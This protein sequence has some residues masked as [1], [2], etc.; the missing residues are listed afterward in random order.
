MKLLLGCVASLC[1]GFHGLIAQPG[2]AA[3]A[4]WSAKDSRLANEY[5]S[6]LVDRPE[7]GRVVDLLWELYAKRNATRLLLDNIHTQAAAS[8]HPSVLLVE[9]HLLR[10]SGDL[11]RAAALYDEVL[12]LKPKEPLALRARAEVASESG[13][14]K[15]AITL[16]RQLAESLPDTDNTKPE[17]WM[18]LGNLALANAQPND[19]AESW[20]RAA[21][22]RPKDM[23]MARSIAQLLLR[24]GFPERAAAFLEALAKASDPQQRL[25]ALA[26][27]SR[28]HEL[29]DQFAKADAALREGL[30]ILDFHDAR[31]AE[32]FLRRVR[33]HERFGLLEDLRAEVTAEAKKQPA[34]ELALSNRVRF[35]A[36]TVDVDDRLLGLRELVKQVP[37][38]DNYRWELVRALL[39]HEGADEAAKLL[40]ERLH[41][42]ASDLPALVLLRAEAEL[43]QG[44]NAAAVTRLQTLL[45]QQAGNTDVEKAVL[46]FAQERTLDAI[47]ESVLQGR[48]ERD[49]DKPEPVF[50]LATFYKSRQQTDKAS[51]L[52]EHFASGIQGTSQA[53]PEARAAAV[54]RYNDA[55]TFLAAGGL[56]EE[57]L[58]LQKAAAALSANGREEL[59]RLADFSAESGRG[60]EAVA[61]LEQ[62]LARST[63]TEERYDIDERLYAALSGAQANAEKKI[64]PVV[65]STEFKLPAF[66]SGEGFGSDADSKT[67][68]EVKPAQKQLAEYAR[69]VID[70]ALD[71]AADVAAL[72]RGVW[73]L[74]QAYTSG[75]EK[76]SMGAALLSATPR[77]GEEMLNGLIAEAKDRR[78]EK[79]AQLSAHEP[80]WL[81]EAQTTRGAYTLLRRLLIDP[82]TH[83]RRELALDLER[84]VLDF[85]LLD[86][87]RL[88][89]SRQLALLIQ[90]DPA[91]RSQ[92][93]LRLAEQALAENNPEIAALELE[94]AYKEQPGSEPL[95]AALTQCYQLLKQPD[96]VLPLWRDAI[97]RTTGNAGNPLRERYAELLLKA[98]K[99]PEHIETQVGLVESETDIK[100]RREIFTRFIDR[101]AWSDSAN[102]DLAATIIQDRLKMVETALIERSRRHPFDGF[103]HEALAA[104]YEKRGDAAKAFAAMRQAYY[105]SPDTPFSLDQLRAA[106]LRVGD[107]KAATY[108]QKQIVATALAKDVASE[109]RQLV[110][111]L[112]Q[113]FQIAEAD[114]VRRRLESRFSQDAVALED[115]AQ[116]YKETGQDEAERRVYEQ[117]ERVRSWDARSTLRLALK[118][119]AVSDEAAAEKHLR[120]ILGRAQT[121]NS[122]A[123]LPPE[124]WPFPLSDERKA[125]VS[126][127]SL[128]TLVTLLEGTRGLKEEE[129]ERL[130]TFLTYPR[131]ELVELP[132]DASQVRLRGIE[133]LAKL[134]RS[135]G[136]KTLSDWTTTWSQNNQATPIEKLWALYYAGA[137][138]ATQ[139]ALAA[140]IAGSEVLDLEFVFAWLMLRSQG[141][142][143]TL[144]WAQ[145]ASLN[146]DTK[147]RRQRVLQ[148]VTGM[149]AEAPGFHFEPK[150]LR[151]L[152]DAKLLSNGALLQIVRSFQDTQRYEEAMALVDGVRQ[153]VPSMRGYYAY[154]LASFAQAAEQWDRQRE[155]LLAVLAEPTEPG[156]Y[157]GEEEDPFIL[158]ASALARLAHSPQERAEMLAQAL[159]RLSETP[160]SSLTT[161]RKAALTALAGAEEPAA[162]ALGYYA[163][164]EFIAQH[165]IAPP[166]GLMP[167]NVM[168]MEDNNHLRTYWSDMRYAGALLSQQGLG[169]LMNA[170]DDRI[171]TRLGGVPLGPRSSDTFSSWRTGRLVRELRV[172]NYPQRQRLI[173]E[174]LASVDMHEED[175]VDTLTELGREL[176]LQGM[177][178]ECIEVYKTLPNRAPT[179]NLYAGY[180]IRVCELAMEPVP[181]REYVESLFGKDP[182]YK[183]QGIGDEVL[184]EKHARF[185]AMEFNETRLRE[186]AIK[187]EGFTRVMEGRIPDEVP[188]L[189]E[190]AL[191]REK[192]GDKPG[193]LE[194]WQ[195]VQAAYNSVTPDAPPDPDLE[196]AQHRATLLHALGK[197]KQAHAVLTTVVMK[198]KPLELTALQIIQQRGTLAAELA[199]WDDFRT[200]VTLA[201]EAKSSS[202]VLALTTL[203]EAKAR[204][205]EALNF[206]TQAERSLKTPDDRL[207]LRLARLKLLARDPTWTPEASRA[208]IA[209]LLR[210]DSRDETTMRQMLA[211]M[212][213]QNSKADTRAASAWISLLRT[214]TRSGSDPTL[215]AAALMTFAK[216]LPNATLPSE[217]ARAWNAATDKDRDCLE[218]A[219]EVL[220]GKLN[221]LN[222][223][224]R[225]PELKVE[226]T[227]AQSHPS[228]TNHS[229]PSALSGNSD[230]GNWAQSVCA[231]LRAI[232]AGQHSRLQPIML[233]TAAAM[234]DESRVRQVYA[235]LVRMPLPRAP[236]IKRWCDALESAGHVGLAREYYALA[237]K[238][239][240]E[241]QAV[242]TELT[243]ARIDFHLRQHE[244]EVAETLLQQNYGSFIPKAAEQ[245]VALYRA[246]GKLGQL[247]AELP[248]YWL[249]KGVEHEVRFLA[250]KK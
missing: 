60:P 138:E 129:T 134:L 210:S 250:G 27:L 194:A 40:D 128:T 76:S 207:A 119:L 88:L 120:D 167:Q 249:P 32:L 173:R 86:E 46:A 228:T 196:C 247:D 236:E 16:Q 21:K 234:N 103:Y 197:A 156:T 112:E 122:L 2:D 164:G 4:T 8:R 98:R 5:L 175:S 223:N 9:A 44:A 154:M 114:K 48:I 23:A 214:E 67:E 55:A 182:V 90:R 34:T 58:R 49:A 195:G 142:S 84:L 12:K 151:A 19:A 235:D 188:Y 62:A 189:R 20:E 149:L 25:D 238:R 15:L 135:Q 56:K 63:T 10:K 201:V 1:L 243:L 204:N 65:T 105:T 125:N 18:Q 31:Y 162:E 216:H 13:D 248:K 209:A 220:I 109:S 81:T 136:G 199:L 166:G 171:H 75:G 224:S 74:R 237:A 185:L 3:T 14:T 118:C 226:S 203:L 68:K 35:A 140:T 80:W 47:V 102:G 132:D 116:Y 33:L 163:S 181:G 85:A 72:A 113:T 148:V 230:F 180:F 69:K 123:S 144:A 141:M 59:V 157:N 66:I 39:D 215:A 241:A 89:A 133:E 78:L 124:R 100:R 198:K 158:A 6:L 229:S 73:W 170:V 82:Q 93:R 202:T 108:F 106:A 61:L 26:D 29:G 187:P 137:D 190:L 169:K 64:E 153:Q 159:H 45:K 205:T 130:R 160:A 208:Q 97:A 222:P 200:L 227:M 233:R 191:L 174:H 94:A 91:N 231:A 143:E 193:A 178:R 43:R 99:L 165:N 42:D 104:V 54:R 145:K 51:A 77:S 101:L 212:T 38:A 211:W 17:A 110:Q 87:N 30:S 242:S 71:P 57:A 240:T 146:D 183:P 152:A 206:L 28:V 221:A 7:Y 41:G 117:I 217:V 218:L 111:L 96:K 36:A 24:A 95:L 22:L 179:N 131:P 213:E 147:A 79:I 70:A 92:Y 52:L 107:L 126:A 11:K 53:T 150:E 225:I 232:P 161:V 172:A 239:L 176:E 83:T 192:L 244:Y 37:Q 155:Y 245:I 139:E 177:M 121:K 127:S 50:E 184:R 168:R 186:L 246:W 219:A 115:L